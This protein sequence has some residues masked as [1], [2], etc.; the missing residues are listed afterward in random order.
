MKERPILFTGPMV[1]ALLDGRK[2]QTRRLVKPQ[3][4]EGEEYAGRILASTDKAD[5][6]KW[7][8]AAG[9]SPLYTSRTRVRCPFGHVGDQLWVRENFKVN[10]TGAGPRVT[11]QEDESVQFF[12]E[13]CP[14]DCLDWIADDHVWRPSIFM[15]RY[16]SRLSL[17]V[18][19]V[20]VERLQDISEAHAEAEGVDFLRHHPDFDETL[21]AVQ[22][23]KVLWESINGDGSWALNPWVW[24]IEFRRVTE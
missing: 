20:R 17:E 8:W 21:T 9:E 1:R 23:Y 10:G 18:M 3:P 12:A 6:G 15:R 7:M 24:V 19:T 4:L 13:T 5:E 14:D 16:A 2:T 22:L 11:Y